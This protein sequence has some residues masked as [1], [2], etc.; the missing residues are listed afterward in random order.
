[1]SKPIRRAGRRSTCPRI[2]RLE[3]RQLLSGVF[4]RLDGGS[5]AARGHETITLRLS[6]LDFTMPTG[7]ALVGFA[8]LES[9]GSSGKMALV[10]GG[11]VLMHRSGRATGVTELMLASV[12]RGTV[13]LQM[14]AG[15]SAMGRV[16]I[17]V[18]LVGDV[19]G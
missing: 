9:G 2:E 15:K 5:L 10:S 14:S 8:M 7:R 11:Q 16:S 3:C 6:Q 13:K 12:N 4:A 17:V 18:Y 1:M 19:N